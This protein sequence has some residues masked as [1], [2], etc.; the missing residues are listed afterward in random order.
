VGFDDLNPYYD[1]SLKQARLDRLAARSG[2]AF[3]Q[4]SVEDKAAVEQVFSA[5][6]PFDRVIHLAAQAGV[7]YSLTHPQAYIDS[8][9]T[10]FLHMLE[11]CLHRAL[12]HLVYASSNSVYGA[13]VKSPFAETDPTDHPVSLYAAT[14]RANEMMAHTYSHLF[15]VPATGLRFFT[16]YGPWGRP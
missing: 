4:A 14:K 2:F 9:V 12:A 16:V 3:V 1:V 11:A 15:G 7:R 6:G 5:H 13:N 8:N 10:G